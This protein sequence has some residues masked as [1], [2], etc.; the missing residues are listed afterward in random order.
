[1][2]T[3][4]NGVF[5]VGVSVFALAMSTILGSA[6]NILSNPAP[7]SPWIATTGT[8]TYMFQTELS[9]GTRC[10][11]LRYKGQV[12]MSCKWVDPTPITQNPQE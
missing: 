9:D 11:A 8:D 1:M 3:R 10:V 12:T 2:T 5:Y 7:P 4:N 6:F